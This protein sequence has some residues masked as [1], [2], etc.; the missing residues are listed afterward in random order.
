[1]PAGLGSLLQHRQQGPRRR[2]RLEGLQEEAPP[3]APFGSG[4]P[5]RAGPSTRHVTAVCG[6]RCAQNTVRSRN[7]AA[8]ARSRAGGLRGFRAGSAS[9]P[10]APLLRRASRRPPA[11]LPAEPSRTAAR[12]GR[13]GPQWL[14]ASLEG[15]D[16][17]SLRLGTLGGARS[18]VRGSREKPSRRAG[19]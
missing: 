4:T 18:G 11:S 19:T 10:P 5:P 3:P 9:R 8:R 16:S 12:W 1:M 15:R 6:A 13:A 14:P 7:R 17:E 2:P